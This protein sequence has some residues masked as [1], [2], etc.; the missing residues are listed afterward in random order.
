MI[1]HKK[2][3]LNLITLNHIIRIL[4]SFRTR[5]LQRENQKRLLQIKIMFNL[6]YLYSESVGEGQ[7]NY[8]VIYQITWT[9]QKSSKTMVGRPYYVVSDSACVQKWRSQPC[10]P[11]DTTGQM[12]SCFR[13]LS[14]SWKLPLA[15]KIHQ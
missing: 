6:N 7:R 4:T 10:S 13:G 2:V 14:T 1:E 5:N 12:K 3:T 8:Q 11:G 9:K 15:L